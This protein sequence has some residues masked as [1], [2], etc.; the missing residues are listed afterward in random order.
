MTEQEHDDTL[1]GGPVMC[2]R[3]DRRILVRIHGADIAGS[4]H[5]VHEGCLTHEE[6]ADLD[7]GEILAVADSAFRDVTYDSSA[8][9][10][11]RWTPREG[12]DLLG[13]NWDEP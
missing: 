5:Y 3:C 13:E 6:L 4:I 7:A 8:P 10:L 1:D 11:D 12:V 9:P 2:V